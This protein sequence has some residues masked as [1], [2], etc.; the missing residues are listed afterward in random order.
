VITKEDSDV[1]W[2]EFLRF[3]SRIRYNLMCIVLCCCTRKQRTKA[4]SELYKQLLLK[5]SEEHLQ[6]ALDVRSIVRT[7]KYLKL[8]L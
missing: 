4:D 6:Q 2:N 5:S 3:R 8:L 1:M 7:N